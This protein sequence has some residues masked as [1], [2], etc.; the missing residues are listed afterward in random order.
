MPALIS[1]ARP[2]GRRLGGAWMFMA[3]PKIRRATAMVQTWS[4]SDG[5]A[6]PL[7]RVPGLARKFWTMISWMW[8]CRSCTSRMASSASMR[9]SRVSPM[10]IRMPV[11]KGTRARPAA[12]RVARR[13]AGTLSGEPKCGPPRS[14]QPVRRR[15]Q[16]DALRHRHL[17]QAREPGLVHHAGIEMRQQPGLL[18]H[19]RGRGLQIVQRRLRAERGKSLARRGV[20]QLRLIAEREQRLLAAGRLSRA[21]DRRAPPPATDSAARPRAARARRCSSGRRRGTAWS[22]G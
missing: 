8:P 11:V 1:C 12:S 22:A 19:Q 4:S 7:M 10:P 14:R 13:T 17:A 21:R 9:S 3:G 15:L 20:A 2:S 5:S 16:H 18:Q 6:A